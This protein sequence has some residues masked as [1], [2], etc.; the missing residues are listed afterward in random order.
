MKLNFF[1]LNTYVDLNLTTFF[2]KQ[3]PI[4]LVQQYFRTTNFL[5]KIKQKLNGQISLKQI[6]QSVF[7]LLC[8]YLFENLMHNFGKICWLMVYLFKDFK[9]LVYFT[10]IIQVRV[11]VFKIKYTWQCTSCYEFLFVHS[12]EHTKGNDKL[13]SIEY[14]VLFIRGL[15][16]WMLKLH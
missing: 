11:H 6:F 12:V 2:E 14:S 5:D 13:N 15:P 1:F 4:R 16:Y 9:G 8:S 10:W 7:T 3:Y